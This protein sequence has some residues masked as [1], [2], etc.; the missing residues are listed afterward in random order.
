MKT[1]ALIAQHI[2]E[3]FEGGNWT[4]VNFRDT[5]RDISYRDAGVVTKASCN[6]IAAIVYHS[7]FYNTLVRRRL[8]GTAG[9]EHDRDSFK[10]TEIKN[11]NDWQQLKNECFQSAHDLAAAVLKLSDDI[12]D[13]PIGETDVTYYKTL[14]GV[15]EHLHYHLGQIVFLKRLARFPSPQLQLSNSL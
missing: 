15:V 5:L 13:T 4:D 2:I 6:T 9:N 10:V 8:E 14:H 7:A 1:A 3:T 12:L 11:E